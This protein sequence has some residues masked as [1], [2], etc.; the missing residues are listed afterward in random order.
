V[1]GQAC[2]F[3][4]S[5][6]SLSSKQRPKIAAS[7][8]LQLTWKHSWFGGC[9]LNACSIL[10]PVLTHRHIELD[11]SKINKTYDLSLVMLTFGRVQGDII[12]I[13]IYII[14]LIIIPLYPHCSIDSI[15][16]SRTRQLDIV[17]FTSLCIYIPKQTFI[18]Q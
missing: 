9:V 16:H 18:S 7:S 4:K 14:P 2:N 10:G 5:V 3:F 17:G 15:L 8:F 11:T 6:K 12:C 1:M 13:C